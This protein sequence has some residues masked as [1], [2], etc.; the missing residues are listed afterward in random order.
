MKTTQ[1]LP[2]SA[3]AFLI[4]LI[5]MTLL[6]FTIILGMSFLE[7]TELGTILFSFSLR[8]YQQLLD[9]VYLKVLVKTVWLALMATLSCLAIGFPVAYYLARVQ[10][11]MKSLGL[12]LLFIPFWTNFILRIYGIVSLFGSNGILNQLLMFL[13]LPKASILYT[14]WGVYFGL[15]Y[16][17]LPFLVVPIY[18]SLEKLDPFL[19]EAAFDLGATRFQTFRKVILPNIKEG[20]FIGSIFVFIPMLGEYVIPDLL[21]GAKEAF[22]GKV[23]VEQFFILQDWP[24][25]SAIATMLS[26]LLLAALWLQNRWT[27]KGL[28]HAI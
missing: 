2:S 22:L 4:W 26:V 10:G 8:N 7:R 12:I 15:V 20:L 5:T 24:L 19:R 6:P 17:Y 21:G 3:W 23:M 25:G 9:W 16:N 28:A 18:S 1:Y 14:R 27:S 13:G 11:T